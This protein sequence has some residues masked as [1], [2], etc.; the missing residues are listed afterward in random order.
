MKKTLLIFHQNLVMGGVEKVT[1]NLIK[2][3]DKK[4]F[5]VKLILVE[6]QG[7]LLQEIP[8]DIEVIYLLDKIYP[9]EPNIIVKIKRYITKKLYIIHKKLDI[10]IKK[11]DII[12]NMNM[13]NM[14]LNISLYPYRNKKIGWIHGN[15]MNDLDSVFN[16]INYK[17]FGQYSV[18]LNVS[19]QGMDDFN[20]KFSKLKNKS[21]ALYNSF[22]IDNLRKKAELE[23]VKENNYLISLGRLSKEKGFDILIDAMKLLRD[24][25]FDEKLYIIGEGEERKNL[26]NKINKYKLQNNIFLL[27]FKSN[28]YP[29]LKNAK[30]CILS[31][32]GEGLPTV[33]IEALSC[34]CPIVSTNCKCGPNE[35][36]ENGRYGI[37]VHVGS[38]EELKTG[39][40]KMILDENL[41]D[42]FRKKSLKRAYDFSNK[43]ILN[44][45]ENIIES[46][47]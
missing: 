39:I 8:K 30:M 45:L 1:L 19:V 2:N 22:D 21:K 16:K 32:L 11:D 44:E 37:L 4:K 6:K 47:Q 23:E 12:L 25:G 14:L 24:E 42:N 13:R 10:L 5:N 15:I 7:E 41:R 34:E 17:F 18:I 26:E 20:R 38:A 33:L 35:I 36:L 31:S 40:K 3:I 9:A 43:R 27:G 29:I 28:P 46:L